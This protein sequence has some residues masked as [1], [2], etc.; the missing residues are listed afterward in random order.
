MASDTNEAPSPSPYRFRFFRAGGVDQVVLDEGALAHLGEL[1][2]KLWLALACPTRGLE[3]DPR[4]LDL[5]DTD[6]DGRIRP[7]ELVA[8]AKWVREA[9]A[10][11]GD[12]WKPLPDDEL[13]LDAFRKDTDT[14][15]ALGDRAR[16][17]LTNLGK[18]D[19][20]AIRLAD[21]LDTEKIFVQTKLN[22]D[23][24][25]PVGATDDAEI[26]KTI[27][28]II[29]VLGSVKDRSGEPGVDRAKADAFFDQV[30]KHVAWLDQASDGSRVAG[31]ATDAAFGAMTAVQGKV[32][33]YFMRARLAA[34][35]GELATRLDASPDEAGALGG[36]EL[37]PSDAEVARWPLA[38]V[39]AGAPLSLAVGVNPAWAA[40]IEAF[41]RLTVTPLLGGS[42][43]RSTL[44]EA[45]WKDVQARLAPFAAWSA[46]RPDLPIGTLGSARIRE[47]AKGDAR[48]KVNALIA[49]DA[50]LEAEN[51]GIES[52]E[53]A[54]RFRK[55]L[56]PLLRN[57]INFSDF[58]GKR[59]GIFQTGTL[60]VD[61]RSCELCLP[62]HDV[63]KHAT[64]AGL[65][66]AYLVYCDCT[67]KGAEKRVIVAAI[68]AGDVDNLL[69]GRNGVF[70]DRKGDDWDATIT[71]ILENPI[72][73][74]QAFLSPYKR[75][76]R[77]IE[78]Q[79]AKRAAAADDQSHKGLTAHAAEMTAAEPAAPA[80]AAPAAAGAPAGPAAGAGPKTID[81][82]T[83][84]AIGVA[85]GGLATFL[86]SVFATFTGLGMWMP[87]GLGAL[88]LAISGPSMLI[89]WLK[90]RQRNIGPI[91]DA[92]GW[93]VNAFA[94]INVPFGGA[95]TRTAELPTGA[96]R[97]LD[98][99]FA[100]KR[101]PYRRYVALAIV[102]LLAGLWAAGKLDLFLPTEAQP[103]SVFHQATPA[104]PAAKPAHS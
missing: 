76:L 19:A 7:P 54:I 100:E 72:S 67:R 56:V 75:F 38:R 77:A 14:G 91:L 26:Q 3:L 48:E 29:A 55:E 10:K 98:D 101:T 22:G 30:A 15:R 23:G 97:L 69:V 12:L 64:L 18:K 52:V 4:T 65:A 68:T 104:S 36:R 99:P 44:T 79:V 87:L 49:E 17:I 94:R 9:F 80:P 62:V 47:L 34:Y 96:T 2:E 58:Y 50:A 43:G 61:G 51:S 81:I 92:N 41:T 21:V 46:T 33:D 60:F 1:D 25:V 6:K 24:I 82:G 85:V 78:E 63:A 93:A 5:I 35:A 57:F 84:A 8:A 70:Y 74:R 66:K 86:S 59:D 88:L 103:G 71:K 89:A 11:L 28:D 53:K 13:P 95:L 83:V 27:T 73:V 31:D 20:T 45:E 40:K 16:R 37:G 39:V 32:D 90:L 102:V 42:G